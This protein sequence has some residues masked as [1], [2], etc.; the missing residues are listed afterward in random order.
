MAGEHGDAD[1]AL[2]FFWQSQAL[3]EEL[4][5]RRGVAESLLGLGQIA[6]MQGRYEEAQGVLEQAA[7]EARAGGDQ[8]LLALALNFIGNGRYVQG[9]W[10]SARPLFEQ[11]REVFQSI[12]NQEGVAIAKVQIG[13]CALAGG[14]Q[15]EARS[16]VREGLQLAHEFDFRWGTLYGLDGAALLAARTGSWEVAATLLGATEL[17]RQSTPAPQIGVRQGAVAAVTAALDPDTLAELWDKGSAMPLDQAISY[18]LQ[19][20]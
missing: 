9:D 16:L 7:R 13:L 17:P 18:A 1:S 5:D 20:L 11:V 6:V 2:A 10:A 4:G 12:G 8:H 3:Y 19:H 14:D 15:E